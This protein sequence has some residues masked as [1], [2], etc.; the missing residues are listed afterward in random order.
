[1][2]GGLHGE[3]WRGDKGEKDALWARRLRYMDRA[4]LVA[5]GEKRWQAATRGIIMALS[6][7]A[8]S[9]HRGPI[10]A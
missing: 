4:E 10:A 3:E 2:A 6:L 8:Q 9:G 7:L 5:G 1:M